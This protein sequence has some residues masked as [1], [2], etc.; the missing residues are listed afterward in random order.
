MSEILE[1]LVELAKQVARI[2]QRLEDMEGQMKV[3]CGK[4]D[5]V[6]EVTE[7]R[8][9]FILRMVLLVLS[10]LA[11]VVVSLVRM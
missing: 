1:E 4:I 9:R 6:K 3:L 7:A 10:T 8:F 5:E 11:T 2:E